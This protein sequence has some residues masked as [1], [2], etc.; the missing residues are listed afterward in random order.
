FAVQ[1]MHAFSTGIVIIGVQKLIAES[2]AEERTGAAQGIAYFANGIFMAL[3][4]LLSGPLYERFGAGG[5]FMMA[6]VAACG[7]GLVLLARLSPVRA[8]PHSSASGG[9]TS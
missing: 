9:E 5:F 7:L 2:I 1:A 6:V 3:F 4:T 8:H